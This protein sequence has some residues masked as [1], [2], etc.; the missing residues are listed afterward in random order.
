MGRW[1]GLRPLEAMLHQSSP[2]ASG[3]RWSRP[4]LGEDFSPIC[5]CFDGGGGWEPLQSADQCTGLE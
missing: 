2:D 5:D 3:L 1:C 4:L